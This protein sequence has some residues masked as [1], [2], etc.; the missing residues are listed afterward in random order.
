MAASIFIIQRF[1]HFFDGD[2]IGCEASVATDAGYFTTRSAAEAAVA[3]LNAPLR[4]EWLQ[5]RADSRAAHDRHIRYVDGEN[6]KRRILA[7]A[8]EESTPLIPKAIHRDVK[9]EDYLRDREYLEF[10]VLEVSRAED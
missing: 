1:C 10:D 2:H 4:E 9:F 6:R 5:H 3:T 8:G 7:R